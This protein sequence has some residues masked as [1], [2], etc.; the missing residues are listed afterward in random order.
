MAAEN[1]Y[2]ITHDPP[3]FVSLNRSAMADTEMVS[4]V[5]ST[6]RS[7]VSSRSA[8][9]P[10]CR[11]SSRRRSSSRSDNERGLL[12]PRDLPF[13][14]RRPRQHRCE[15]GPHLEIVEVVELFSRTERPVQRL[16]YLADR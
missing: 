13:R 5:A 7:S 1:E 11:F 10:S 16:A 6:R 8:R 12:R 15:L 9:T 14:F 3:P 4:T 2:R